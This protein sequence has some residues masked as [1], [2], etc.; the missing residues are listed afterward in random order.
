MGLFGQDKDDGANVDKRADD[1]GRAD[2][3]TGENK[4]IDAAPPLKPFTKGGSH[5][6]SSKPA[7][8]ALPSRTSSPDIPRRITDIPG[9]P[10]R[11]DRTRQAEESG[12]TLT[13]GR[14][15]CLNGQI[16]SCETLVVEGRVEAE[17]TEANLINVAETGTFVGKSDV[18][19]ADIS[20][21]YDGDLTVRNRLTLR[22]GGQIK[23]SV[24]YGTLVIEA[25]GEIN[26]TLKALPKDNEA[27]D[28]G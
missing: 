16:S 24:Q 27:G 2:E 9:A 18:Q 3:S 20:G 1:T 11:S 10:R 21:F 17:L 4:S 19:N 8:P 22:P 28:E 7:A 23:G 25:G 15:I 6:G 26:G 12:K 14:D 13:V 5:M